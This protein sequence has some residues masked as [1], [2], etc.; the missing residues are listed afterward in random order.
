MYE[1]IE[2][3]FLGYSKWSHFYNNFVFFIYFLRGDIS[4]LFGDPVELGELMMEHDL[5]CAKNVMSPKLF[6]S[7]KC[8]MSPRRLPIKISKT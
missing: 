2:I 3:K 6:M 7:Q 1:T 4:K 8:F 5:F